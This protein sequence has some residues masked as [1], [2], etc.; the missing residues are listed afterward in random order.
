MRRFRGDFGVALRGIERHLGVF[1]VVI[2]MDDVMR[3]AGMVGILF[4]YLRSDGASAQPSLHASRVFR[5]DSSH[6]RKRIKERRLR[7]VGVVTID[8]FHGG[9][10]CVVASGLVALSVQYPDRL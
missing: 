2:R 8:L 6:Q 5:A 9:G 7:I 4:V 10:I 3:R 1:G